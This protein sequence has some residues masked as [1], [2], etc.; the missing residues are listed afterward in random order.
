MD[1]HT[2]RAGRELCL[3]G[4][5]IFTFALF[6][7]GVGFE[8][9]LVT[10]GKTFDEGNKNQWRTAH[11]GSSVNALFVIACGCAQ[12]FF[13]LS[14]KQRSWMIFGV[15]L[16]GWGNALGY[17]IGAIVGHRGLVPICFSLDFPYIWCQSGVEA[18]LN[19]PS[20]LLFVLSIF[21][22]ILSIYFAIVGTTTSNLPKKVR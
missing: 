8:I 2:Y 21:G 19:I 11:V 13:V 16:T 15:K 17:T 14:K 7:A 18:A 20:N 10:S 12:P 5:L 6:V 4:F 3:H 1:D 22:A 9:A